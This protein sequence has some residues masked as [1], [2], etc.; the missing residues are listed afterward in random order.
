MAMHKHWL[1]YQDNGGNVIGLFKTDCRI[2]LRHMH[3][4]GIAVATL[5]RFRNA[6]AFN[7]CREDGKGKTELLHVAGPFPCR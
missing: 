7:I 6:T 1:V 2:A 3:E 4:H 5:H